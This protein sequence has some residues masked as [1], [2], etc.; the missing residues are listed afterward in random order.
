MQQGISPFIG[1]KDHLAH[2][3]VY[4][5]FSEKKAVKILSI[6]SILSGLIV[7]FIADAVGTNMWISTNT[8]LVI[9]YWL[10]VWVILQVLYDKGMKP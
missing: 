7:F 4:A 9:A 10:I 1:G 2:H 3:L 6:V 5:G 8:Y